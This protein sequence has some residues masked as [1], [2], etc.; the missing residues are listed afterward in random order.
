M[1]VV[2]RDTSSFWV[3]IEE[4]GVG[5][6]EGLEGHPDPHYILPTLQAST[7]PSLSSCHYSFL[8]IFVWPKD[9]SLILAVMARTT[10]DTSC[11]RARELI[12]LGN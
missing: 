12:W 8:T 9:I 3:C 5:V 4:A 1:T 11:K 6:G 7:A 2:F 10:M